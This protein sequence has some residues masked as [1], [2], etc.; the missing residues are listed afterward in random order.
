MREEEIHEVQRGFEMRRSEKLERF[1]PG[2]VSRVR[3]W[4][5]T[6]EYDAR[7]KIRFTT[8]VVGSCPAA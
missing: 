2:G 6:V 8:L 7:T 3:K 1:E 4:D 5:Y